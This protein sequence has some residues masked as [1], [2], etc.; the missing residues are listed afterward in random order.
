ML[1]TTSDIGG[2]EPVSTLSRLPAAVPL[3][4]RRM[5]QV[6]NSGYLLIGDD[7]LA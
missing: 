7:G 1:S 5:C 4:P 2:V 3:R 6:L